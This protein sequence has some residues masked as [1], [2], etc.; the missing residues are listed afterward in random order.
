[1]PIYVI[2]AYVIFCGVPVGVAISI[3]ARRRRIAREIA[4]WR[5]EIS[6]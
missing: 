4:R 6:T 5:E 1:M 3:A 2:L